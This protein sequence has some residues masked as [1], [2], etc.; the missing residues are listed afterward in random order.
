MVDI[1]DGLQGKPSFQKVINRN[2]INDKYFGT[3]NCD[4][5]HACCLTLPQFYGHEVK[6]D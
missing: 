4:F 5:D 1:G 2:S 3:I 6:A